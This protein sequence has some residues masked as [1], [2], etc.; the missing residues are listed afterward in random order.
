MKSKESDQ[1]YSLHS[2][3]MR[4]FTAWIFRLS[5]VAYSLFL[6]DSCK[7][8]SHVR[9]QEKLKNDSLARFP[10]WI[11][12]MDSP[13]VNYNATVTAFEKY[14]EHRE[15]P[16]EDD[17]E[18]QDIYGKTKSGK[19]REAEAHRTIA[20]VYEYKQFLNWKQR[21][22]NFIKSDGTL[23]TPEEILAAWKKSQTDTLTR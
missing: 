17:G 8:Q 18:G 10:Y 16:T 6:L 1:I 15:K 14:W 4:F 7:G 9:V 19:E 20:Y 13:G 3:G 5:V 2:Q 22:K 23:M 12:M 21:N 11:A